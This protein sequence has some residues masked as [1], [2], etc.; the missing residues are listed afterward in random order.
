MRRSALLVLVLCLSLLAAGG[1]VTAET[2]EPTT[3][4]TIGYV[5]GYWYDDELPV[6]DR[7]DATVTDEE[8][9]AVVARSMAR[10]E[11]IRE[12][13]FEERVPVEVITRSAF[14]AELDE[15][16]LDVTDEQALHLN[17]LYEA[18]YIV[19]R[20]TDAIEEIEVLFGGA[21][22]GYY[23]PQATQIVLI[24]DGDEPEVDEVTLAHELLHALQDQHWDLQRV[25]RGTLDQSTAADGLIEGDAVSVDREYASR[26]GSEWACL[27]P[28]P[29]QPDL[30]R[31][32]EGL[33]LQFFHPYSD[34]PAYVEAILEEDGWAGVNDRYDDIPATTSEIIHPLEYR[35]LVG[36]E[37]EDR[38]SDRWSPLPSD[39]GAEYNSLGE[40]GLATMFM[41]QTIRANEPIGIE[42]EPIQDGPSSFNYAWGPTD[43]WAGDRFVAYGT[44]ASTVEETGYVWEI[45]WTDEDERDEFLT[46][47]LAVLEQV[48]AEPLGEYADTYEL[49]GAFPGVL[50]I[51]VDGT[52]VRLTGA[53]SLED[54]TEI[55][56]TLPRE[57]EDTLENGLADDDWTL[58]DEIP[59]PGVPAVVLAA[60]L[61]LAILARRDR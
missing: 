21:V 32:N 35:E 42:D 36:L 10:V 17:V 53:P 31:F 59:A 4:G 23:D 8:L 51:T 20:D 11:V 14:E 60:A 13:P 44:N 3:E 52:T 6:D 46:A 40:M 56:E 54:L 48:D 41:Y 58:V 28:G 27:E 9:D 5:D 24:A 61:A 37:A 30:P 50:A 43:G 15:L 34:G 49:G 38:S 22:A 25:E 19:D 47:Y 29:A 45:A 7:D 39:A 18:V 12:L 16:L 55:D 2:D 33:L 57:G 26:C 1:V